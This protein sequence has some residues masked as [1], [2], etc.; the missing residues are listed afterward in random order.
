MAKKKWDKGLDFKET[1]AKLLAYKKWVRN[2]PPIY[3]VKAGI[4]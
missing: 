3:E 1:L 4:P 2:S